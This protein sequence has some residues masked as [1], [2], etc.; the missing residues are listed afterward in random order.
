MAYG[1]EICDEEL[2]II[3][4]FL[5]FDFTDGKRIMLKK[6]YYIAYFSNNEKK[7]K[8]DAVPAADLQVSYL[9]Q[10]FSEIGYEVEILSPNIPN[11][12]KK[13]FHIQKGF[14][15]QVEKNI[16]VRYFNCLE[17]SSR[18]IRY[19]SRRI[20]VLS[21]A[22]YLKGVKDG[23]IVIYHSRIFYPFYHLLKRIGRD[24]IL[25]LEEIY[26][27]VIGDDKKRKREI[28]EVSKA[29]AYILPSIPLA[30]E[31]TQ[32][33]KYVL[34]HGSCRNEKQIGMGFHDGRIHVVYAGTFDPRVI[35]KLSLIQAAEYLD[36]RYHIHVIGFGRNQSD[37]DRII[38]EVN[39]MQG[40]SCKVTYD[41]LLL[42]ED[43]I[44][45]L[46]SCDIGMFSRDP[47]GRDINSSFPSKIMSY[48]SNGLHVVAT[49][50][51][52]IERS[53][54]GN[55]VCFCN[56][57]D[58]KDVAD[59]IMHVDLSVPYDSREKLMEIESRLKVNLKQLLSNFD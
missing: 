3:F 1:N 9:S 22:R 10:V 49:R 13:I 17:S 15:K 11:N 42:G 30:E 29:T 20:A 46:Q 34:Y 24:Y 41:G 59:A 23:K 56:T 5:K 26:L 7:R 36:E 40:K 55:I 21:A 58:P 19:F 39:E 47:N 44:S 35:G 50:A 12:G 45:F 25:E 14:V 51:D 31:V 18:I 43:Y 33:K 54:V 27:D 2:E 32:G 8:R 48:L 57:N 6:I 28:S 38:G 16:N 37:V 4:L 52:S 53:E